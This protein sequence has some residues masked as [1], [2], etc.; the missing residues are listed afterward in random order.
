MSTQ[1]NEM[2]V[3][4]INFIVRGN[5]FRFVEIKLLTETYVAKELAER[6]EDAE[7][8]IRLHQR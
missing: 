2:D 4:K 6:Y 5:K 7:W 8:R 1:G 3:R